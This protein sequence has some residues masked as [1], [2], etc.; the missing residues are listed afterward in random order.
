MTGLYL[1]LSILSVAALAGVAWFG[2]KNR[3]DKR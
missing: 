3:S 1:M 2:L